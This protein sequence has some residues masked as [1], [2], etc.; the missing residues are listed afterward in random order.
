MGRILIV[1]DEP[2]IAELVDLGSVVQLEIDRYD[3]DAGA[4]FTVVDIE[5][6]AAKELA[7]LGIWG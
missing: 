1:E 7:T 3:Y 5:R 4:L 2:A 6:D